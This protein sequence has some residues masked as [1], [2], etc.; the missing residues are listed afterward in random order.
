MRQALH[1][2]A[3]DVRLEVDWRE[4]QLA[5]IQGHLQ[6]IADVQVT[7]AKLLAARRD[8]WARQVLSWLVGLL[9]CQL[10]AA[11]RCLGLAGPMLACSCSHPCQ[12]IDGVGRSRVQAM[13]VLLLTGG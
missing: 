5:G 6:H 3:E 10:L 4:R 12:P 13:A 8:A 2:A 9:A 1:K 7:A 11:S